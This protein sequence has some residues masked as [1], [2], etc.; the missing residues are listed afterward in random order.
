M[1]FEEQ[2][3]RKPNKYPWTKEFIESMQN[4]FW[5]SSEFSFQSDIQEFKIKL[6]NQ[7]REIITR[8]LSAISQV[9]VSVKKFWG[10]LGD[11]LPHPSLTDLGYVMAHV[12]VIHNDAYER[13]LSVL[14]LEEIFEQNLKLDIIQG[15]VGYL[16]KYLSKYSSDSKKQYVYALILFTLFIENVS[17][18]SQFY[19]VM[20][21]N[22]FKNVLKDTGQ[23]VDYTKR[24]ELIHAQ[25]G[26]KLINVIRKEHPELF[27]LELEK[28]I[29]WEAQE[30]FLAES[31]L[32]DWMIED[33]KEDKLN[34]EILKEFIKKR[35]NES[36][37]DIKF[38]PVFELNKELHKNMKWFEEDIH[39]N[40]STDFFHKRPTEYSKK[41]QAITTE[42]LF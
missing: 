18:F 5:L 17:L 4:G 16:R 33:F 24:E 34:S 7:E 15:R 6:N 3:A 23:Q 12:E 37:K 21:F 20:W 2:V 1:I 41:S 28:L 39:G 10:R 11:N 35:I 8:T 36:L 22:R 27:D 38:S 30:A 31:R 26:I 25:V 13:L 32:I 9:E 40:T 14:G 29:K 42:E 19:I